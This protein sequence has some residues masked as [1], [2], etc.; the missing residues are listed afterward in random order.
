LLT[1]GQQIEKEYTGVEGILFVSKD[2]IKK[3]VFFPMTGEATDHF[4]IVNNYNEKY[5]WY[6]LNNKD[7]YKTP[8]VFGLRYTTVRFISTH[9]S[10]GTTVRPVKD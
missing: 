3:K 10:T 7:K 4:N 8:I 5:G 6:K 2:D 9:E 1:S